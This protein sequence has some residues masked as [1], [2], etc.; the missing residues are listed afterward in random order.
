MYMYLKICLLCDTPP[1]PV[2]PF[3]VHIFRHFPP[4]PFLSSL[5]SLSHFP[6]SYVLRLLPPW[7][8]PFLTTAN[9]SYCGLEEQTLTLLLRSVRA[10]CN[11]QV[12]KM[13][14]NNLTGKGTF[15]LSKYLK[16]HTWTV[17]KSSHKR[18]FFCLEPNDTRTKGYH[19]RI[20]Y[21][22]F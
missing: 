10:N 1:A 8:S 13:E 14:G 7:Q 15:I 22:P 2:C 12:L 4:S 6:F 11:L 9:V 5:S 18:D 19:Q 3:T 20:P 21:Y 17:L 16:S